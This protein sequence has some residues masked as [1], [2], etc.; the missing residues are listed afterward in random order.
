MDCAISSALAARHLS[1]QYEHD[2]RRMPLRVPPF[3]PRSYDH[4]RQHLACRLLPAFPTLCLSLISALHCHHNRTLSLSSLQGQRRPALLARPRRHVA[5]SSTHHPRR[6]AFE[7]HLTPPPPS[8]PSSPLTIFLLPPPPS[9]TQPPAPPRPTTYRTN[10]GRR[11]R[12]GQPPEGSAAE[13]CGGDGYVCRTLRKA[14]SPT[15]ALV[16]HPI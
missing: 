16:P 7:C 2:E 6:V 12:D 10:H 14:S 3:V 1:S 4:R 13:R 9:L 15:H 8:L 5:T 11:Q